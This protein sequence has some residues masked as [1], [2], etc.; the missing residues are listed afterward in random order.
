MDE[1]AEAVAVFG[2]GGGDAVDLAAVEGLEAA[3]YSCEE[4]KA[5]GYVEGLKAAGYSCAEARAAGYTPQEAGKAA[6]SAKASCC[7]G[8]R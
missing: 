6:P 7:G 8:R 2:E 1:V 5:A 3:G 4:A